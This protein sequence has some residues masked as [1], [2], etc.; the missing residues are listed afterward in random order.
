MKCREQLEEGLT[1]EQEQ[2]LDRLDE[3]YAALMCQCEKEAFFY[4]FCLGGKMMQEVMR[5]DGR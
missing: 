5:F 4:A 1:K 3:Q 2:L